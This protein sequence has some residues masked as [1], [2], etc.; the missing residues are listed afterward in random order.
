MFD[1]EPFDFVAKVLIHM[2]FIWP[3]LDEFLDHWIS[4]GRIF[5]HF[6][7]FVSYLVAAALSVGI[8]FE[9][10]ELYYMV[11]VYGYQ[12]HP[13]TSDPAGHGV[14]MG[15]DVWIGPRTCNVI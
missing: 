4:F 2:L 3:T 13:I 10:F 11:A 7:N 8:R 1:E 15:S 9:K 12:C 5:R 14:G 6:A